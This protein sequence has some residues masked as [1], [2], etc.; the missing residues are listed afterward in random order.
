MGVPVL[1]VGDSVMANIEGAM[2]LAS[3]GAPNPLGVGAASPG[4][5]PAFGS[6][7]G[8]RWADTHLARVL[9]DGGP[10]PEAGDWVS[11]YGEPVDGWQPA[12]VVMHFGGNSTIACQGCPPDGTGGIELWNSAYHQQRQVEGVMSILADIVNARHRPAKLV[13]CA[14]LFVKWYCADSD[15][16]ADAIN[17]FGAGMLANVKNAVASDP[18]LQPGGAAVDVRVVDL[19]PLKVCTSDRDS[20]DCIHL[21]AQG[22]A[23]AASWVWQQVWT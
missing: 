14:G 11:N 3:G 20:S 8:T 22:A 16:R 19:S 18:A 15:P 23:K 17:V 6:L 5:G 12:C 2:G 13:V 4:S 21:S 9:V 10:D 7:G 1:T